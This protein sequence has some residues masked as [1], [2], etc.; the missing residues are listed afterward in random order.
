M[1]PKQS[2]GFFLVK[3]PTFHNTQHMNLEFSLINH[4]PSVKNFLPF[5]KARE[6]VRMTLKKIKDKNLYWFLS[7]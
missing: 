3:L 7:V 4:F 1:F 6:I 5:I 2:S